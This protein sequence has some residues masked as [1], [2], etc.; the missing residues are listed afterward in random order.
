M[1]AVVTYVVGSGR[2]TQVD[3]AEAAAAD[4]P[5]DAVFVPHAEVLLPCQHTVPVVTC[6]VCTR[7]VDIVMTAGHE[8]AD[9]ASRT[10]VVILLGW[11]LQ[12]GPAVL[13]E[14][15]VVWLCSVFLPSV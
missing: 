6:R 11:P 10:I 13:L 7:Y 5:A 15:D 8:G 3:V 9:E 14:A 4:L 1:L 2:H 12:R